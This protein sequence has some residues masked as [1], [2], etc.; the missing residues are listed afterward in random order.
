M[1]STIRSTYTKIINKDDIGKVKAPLYQLPN[2]DFSYGKAAGND[3]EG[4]RALTS[5]WQIHTPTRT[6]TPKKD[7]KTLNK[8]STNNGFSSSKHFRDVA[9]ISK[10]VT[11]NPNVGTKAIRIVLPEEEFRYG[12]SNRP[13]TPMIQVMSNNYGNNAATVSEDIYKA[14]IAE[15]SEIRSQRPKTTKTVQL[16]L[17][18]TAKKLEEMDNYGNNNEF[19]MRQ[20]QKA[21]HKVATF[22]DE[23]IPANKQTRP[24]TAINF[25]H[26]LK[27]KQI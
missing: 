5:S 21:Q 9:L 20:F 13:S 12:I 24:R 11:V 14:R 3:K 27:S 16:G 1:S 17:E 10:G 8:I 19:K 23:Y 15:A 25:P 2:T 26:A 6:A 4:V 22:N 7:F 18:T